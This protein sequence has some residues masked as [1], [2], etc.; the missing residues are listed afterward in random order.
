MLSYARAKYRK[1]KQIIQRILNVTEVPTVK[2]ICSTIRVADSKTLEEHATRMLAAYRS[3]N[4]LTDFHPQYDAQAVYQTC[5]MMKVKVNEE[6]LI[7][8]SNLK[9]MQWS[10]LKTKWQRWIEQN[11]ITLADNPKKRT[12]EKGKIGP[13]EGSLLFV[14]QNLQ[15]D[16]FFQMYLKQLITTTMQRKM[17]RRKPNASR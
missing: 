1:E 9:R 5:K 11:K 16:F 13:T 8:A 17:F 15:K 14:K 6:K 7:D 12:A 2:T 4:H 3:S 10:N